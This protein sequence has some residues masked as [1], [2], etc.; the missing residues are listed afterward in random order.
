MMRQ[1]WSMTTTT[2]VALVL[3]TAV[4]QAQNAATATPPPSPD[5]TVSV[6]EIIVTATKRSEKLQNVPIAV[7]A[8]SS[9]ALKKAGITDVRQLTALAPSL[10][11]TSSA[12]EA[13]GTTARLRGIGTTGDNP[14]LESSV[15]VFIDGVYRNRN[16]VGL[17]DL[18]EVERIEVLRGPQ[19]TLFGRNASAG[20]INVITVQPKFKLGGY[21]DVSY[22]NYNDIR[23]GAGITGPVI[24]DKLAL[25]IDGNFEKR[26]GFLRDTVTNQDYNNRDRWLLRAQ[27]RFTPNDFIEDRFIGDYSRRREQCCAAVTLVRGA[28]AGL[29]EALGGRLGSGGTP[30]G[31]DPYARNSATTPGRDYQQNVDEWGVSNELKLKFAALNVSSITAY[32]DW[33]AHR[34][35]DAD[36]TSLD[37][38]YRPRDGANQEFKTFSQELRAD[39]SLW[40]DRISWL[41]GGYFANERLDTLD[42]LTYGADYQNYANGLIRASIPTFPG[43]QAFSPFIA[44]ATQA[45]LVAAGVPAAVAAAQAAALAPLVGNVNLSGNGQNDLFHQTSNN[46][47]LFTHNIFKVTETLKLTL[48]ARYTWDSKEVTGQQQSTNP[49]CQAVIDSVARINASTAL[50]PATAAIARGTIQALRALPCVINSALDGTSN[51]TRTD[52]QF[53]G[54]AVLSNKF[55]DHLLGYFSYSRGYKAGGFNLDRTGATGLLNSNG[56]LPT[57]T[58]PQQLASALSFLPETVNSYEVGGK[59]SSPTVTFNAALF[60]SD[61]FNY[62]LNTFNGLFFVVTNLPTVQTRGF[63]LEATL[64]PT[65]NLTF[66][67][68]FTLADTRYPKDLSGPLFVQP[69]AT[70]TNPNGGAFF[71]LPGRQLTNAPEYVFTGGVDFNHEIPTTKLTG[72]LHL[73]FRY[74]SELNTGSDLDAEKIQ[75]GVFLLNGTVG[76]NGPENAWALEL[77]SRNLLNANYTQVTFDGPVQGSGTRRNRF[78]PNTQTFDSFLAE[79]RTFGFRVR[80]KF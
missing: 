1:F 43:Y 12:S 16:N 48:G 13:A 19:G 14:G 69:S 4:A 65:S 78:L 35:Q 52:R 17:T 24:G 67:G 75:T 26:D 73:D 46:Y 2:A 44:G 71:Q 55:T 5:A 56:V 47:A 70:N 34:G 77:Y 9:D 49:G 72:F 22:G 79:P 76:L 11:L 50:L 42:R 30:A 38:L 68:G 28:T 20:L 7:T 15:A 80:Y 18:G 41:V 8:L 62:Q 57:G 31:S 74:T 23:V 39:G 66:N 21:A 3:S 40:A 29:I 60:L 6:G 45:R 53:T 51:G 58:T 32:R 33:T 25:R 36:Y 37:I 61:F 63:E 27:A 59:Y 64:R 10:I 54:T